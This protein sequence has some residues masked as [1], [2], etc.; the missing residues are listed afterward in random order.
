MSE[1][2]TIHEYITITVQNTE[3][4]T[5]DCYQLNTLH[6]VLDPK[7]SLLQRVPYFKKQCGEV[8]L[9]I[10]AFIYYPGTNKISKGYLQSPGLWRLWARACRPPGLVVVLH[11]PRKMCPSSRGCKQQK[12]KSYSEIYLIMLFWGFNYFQN[13]GHLRFVE[14]S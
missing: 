11:R 14:S 5:F 3:N 7:Q 12:V 4:T 6:W 2:N 9:F 10:Y 8:F 13:T 1:Y